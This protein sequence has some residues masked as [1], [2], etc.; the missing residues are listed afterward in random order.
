MAE[1]K[2]DKE[3][4]Q[5]IP[6]LAEGELVGLEASLRAEGCRDPLIVW[7]GQSLLLDGHN[8]YAICKKHDIPY[9]TVEIELVDREAAKA[10][11]LAHQMNRRN[12]TPEAAS[13]IRGKHYLSQKQLHPTGRPKKG[14]QTDPPK[15]TAEKLADQYRVGSATIKRDAKLAQIVDKL[16]ETHTTSKLHVRTLLLS[17][18]YGLR[19]GAIVKV[20]KMP[21]AAQKAFL[22]SLAK[23]GRAPRQKKGRAKK[24]AKAVAESWIQWLEKRGD[25]ASDVLQQ[26]AQ[27]FGYRLERVQE[28]GKS[29][30]KSK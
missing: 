12:L 19:R 4:Q 15:K 26:V 10:W 8:R 1:I 22:E 28:G 25:E 27:R 24:S 21:E 20:G 9:K 7:K 5:L 13:Y 16:T 2:I 14:D 3:L 11:I 29:S 6:P 18:D 30:P 23:E 17:R